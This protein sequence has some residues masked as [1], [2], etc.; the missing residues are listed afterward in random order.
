M[1]DAVFNSFTSRFHPLVYITHIL[2]LYMNI[3]IESTATDFHRTMLLALSSILGWVRLGNEY[4]TEYIVPAFFFSFKCR[5]I[6]KKKKTNI[7]EYV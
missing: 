7:K 5:A 1:N 3:R 4:C 2:T 6:L